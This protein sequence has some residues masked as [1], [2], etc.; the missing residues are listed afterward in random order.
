[1]HDYGAHMLV[2]KMLHDEQSLGLRLQSTISDFDSLKDVSCSCTF[3]PHNKPGLLPIWTDRSS[4][5]AE[6]PAE[7]KRE[8]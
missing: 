3:H 5:Y 1:M 8:M 7:P 2:F 4:R 6:D